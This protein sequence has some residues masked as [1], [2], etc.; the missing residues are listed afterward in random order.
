MSMESPLNELLAIQLF[1]HDTEQT[2]D[3]DVVRYK[4]L[5]CWSILDDDDRQLYRDMA[6]GKT[7]LYDE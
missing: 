6:S 3:G 1:E 7:G 4:D 5:T 2:P